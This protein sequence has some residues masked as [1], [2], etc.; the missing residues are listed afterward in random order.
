MPFAEAITYGVFPCNLAPSLNSSVL[1]RI[2]LL[3]RLFQASD[4][5]SFPRHA[6]FRIWYAEAQGRPSASLG[7]IFRLARDNTCAA[8]SD[9]PA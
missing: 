7:Q 6:V 3:D 1:F 9:Q 5:T 8:Q 2:L 4:K